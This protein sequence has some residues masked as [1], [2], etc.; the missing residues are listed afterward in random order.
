MDNTCDQTTKDENKEDNPTK[1]KKLK[2]GSGSKEDIAKYNKEFFSNN[3]DKKYMCELCK[4][5][6][7]FFNKSHHKATKKHLLATLL[8]EKEERLK[9]DKQKSESI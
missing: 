1:D 8:F 6:V 3:K 4:C 5:E 9:T 2:K 7:S